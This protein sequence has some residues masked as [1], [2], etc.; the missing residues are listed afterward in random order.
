MIFRGRWFAHFEPEKVICVCKEGAEQWTIILA[1]TKTH[2]F[3]ITAY[4]SSITEQKQFQ[5]G[6]EINNFEIT[7]KG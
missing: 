3:I 1:P 7:D 4:P 2:M 6:K 5:K